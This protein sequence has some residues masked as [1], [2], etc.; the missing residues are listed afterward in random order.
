MPGYID[1]LLQRF[2]HKPS[3]KPQHSPHA[4]PPRL[5]G[6]DAQK[7]V[8]HDNMPLLPPDRIK[9]IQQIIGTIMYYTRAAVDLTTLVALSSIASEQTKATQNTEN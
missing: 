6:Q 7:P 9:R 2:D 1:K 8:E 4:A 5:F 3:A